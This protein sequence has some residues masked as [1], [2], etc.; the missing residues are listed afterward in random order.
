MSIYTHCLSFFPT[1]PPEIDEKLSTG[2]IIT[3]EGETVTLTC[4]V[5][6][7]PPPVV[8]WYRRPLDQGIGKAKESKLH[9]LY[10]VCI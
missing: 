1:V 8:H 10:I 4:N 3:K 7:I 2:N 5:S 9:N 6:G